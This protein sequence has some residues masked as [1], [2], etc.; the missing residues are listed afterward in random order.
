LTEAPTIGI[1]RLL[2]EGGRFFIPHHQRDYS[3][4]EDQLEQLFED[5]L[6]AEASQHTE[7]F[8]GLMVFMDQEEDERTS[9]ILDGQQRLASTIIILSAIRTWLR[10]QGYST[11]ADQIQQEYIASREFGEQDWEPNL[12]LNASNNDT[13]ER[14]VV[15]DSAVEDVKREL[16]GLNRYDPNRRLLEAIVYYRTCVEGLGNSSHSIAA[17][18]ERLFRLLRYIRDSVKV[19][20][21]S[22]PNEANAYTVFE[23]LNDRGLDLSVLDLI[24]NHLFGKAGNQASLRHMQGQWA[25][26]TGNLTDVRADDFIK[27]WWISRYGRIQNPHLF[28]RFR[29]RVPSRSEARAASKDM[30]ATSEKYAALGVPDDP[31]WRQYSSETREHVGNLRLIGGQQVHPVMLSALDKFPDREVERLM[32][33]LEVLIV[34]Y[35]LIGGGRTGRLEIEVLSKVVDR[36][37]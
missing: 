28:G 17:G 21:L 9:T 5:I 18:A 33:L 32:R 30:L 22:V 23:T 24:K 15:R 11:D 26:M 35:Q 4:T 29:A 36:T 27:A 7:Y 31:I 3:W 20:R 37:P 25:Q 14:R 34:R 12:V 1:G 13:F 10:G 16:Q 8:I 19:V 2:K 6:D